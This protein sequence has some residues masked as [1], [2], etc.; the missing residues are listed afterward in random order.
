[1]S[2]VLGFVLVGLNLHQYSFPF[3]THTIGEYGNGGILLGVPQAI[4]S[5][6]W[7]VE[8]PLMLAQVSHQPPF[9]ITNTNIGLGVNQLSH[10]KLPVWHILAL[11]KPTTWGFFLGV[12]IGL[13]W[14]WWSMV[15]GLFY[16]FFLLFMLISKK[17]I[18]L[19][20]MGSLIV[21]FSPFFQF[22]SMHMSEIAI[23]MALMFISFSHL[24]TS[25]RKR[26]VI[27]NA[28]LLGWS[29]GCF[30]LSFIYPPYQISLAYLLMFMLGGFIIDRYSELNSSQYRILRFI[31]LGV[32]IAV[33]VFSGIVYYYE[34]SEVIRLMSNTVYP[35]MRFSTGGDFD[36]WKLLS[37]NLF[38]HVYGLFQ[39]GIKAAYFFDWKPTNNIC[40]YSSFIFFFPFLI[41]ILIAKCITEK[42]WVD[43][44]SLMVA[45]YIMILLVYMLWGFPNWLCKYTLFSRTP[46]FREIMGLGIANS[47]MMVSMLAKPVHFELSKRLRVSITI[48]WG[49]VLIFSALE[50]FDK[51][52]ATPLT[53]LVVAALFVAVLSY[54]LMSVEFNR[55]VLA[56]LVILS[57]LTTGWFNPLV[58]GGSQ[59]FSES[60]LCRKIL[61]IDA[62]EKGRS[63]WVTFS[64][65]AASA[66]ILRMLGVHSING[67][68]PYPQ[69]NLWKKI[70]P[71]QTALETYN[72]YGYAIFIPNSGPDVIFSLHG[73]DLFSVKV[74]P[75]SDVF[76]TLGV[77]HFLVFGEETGIFD[78]SPNLQRVFS[79][80]DRHIYKRLLK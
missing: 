46:A 4:R 37:N 69:L 66:N 56:V 73:N 79:F 2:I 53:Y 11:F 76:S 72:R 48:V 38:V 24:M 15:L 33:V 77:T 63:S 20:L 41:L 61:E 8:I 49:A 12:D 78:Q 36:P 21:L 19:S 28:L 16:S 9:P 75:N 40:E 29:S 25:T 65:R 60:R 57:I 45:G 51:W 30:L 59:I 47:V 55:V 3:W 23:F 58:H 67:N 74:N 44:L 22:W 43:P 14:M 31:C 71:G 34:A 70:D 52:P 17:Q 35:G 32:P 42:R 62:A 18:Y 80:K 26:I 39:H 54:F 1:M 64:S 27:A 5:D 50:L 6:D 13:S 7:A 10:F 68:F